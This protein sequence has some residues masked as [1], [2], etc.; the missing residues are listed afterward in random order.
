MLQNLV[1]SGSSAPPLSADFNDTKKLEQALR[2]A[3]EGE[4]RFD[5]GSRALYATDASNYRQMPIGVVIPRTID[6]AIQAMRICYQHGAPVLSRGGGTS[7]CGQCCNVAVVLDF[8]KYL[9]QIIDID[10]AGKYAWVQPGTV[11]DDLRHAAEQHGLTFA[12][13]PSTHTHNTLGGMIGNNSCGAHSVMGGET[14]DNVIELDVLTYEGVRMTLTGD[15]DQPIRAAD[16]KDQPRC[17]QIVQQLRDLGERYADQIRERFPEIPRR[18]SGF[19]LPALLPERGFNLARALVGS[20]GTCV[21]VLQAKVRLMDNPAARSLLV[22]G[23]K[24]VYEA[25]DHVPEVMQ[26]KPIALEGIDDRLISD[27][28]AIGLHPDKVQLLP[29]G[30]GWLLVEF[31]GQNKDDADAQAHKL[32]DALK[33]A[34]NAP[35]MK[36]FD[37][38]KVE[39]QIWKIRESGLGATAH[40]P[41]KKITWEGWEDSSVP[42]ENLGKYLRK[43]REL[44]D[45]Y[46]YACD[47]YGHFG[48]GCVHTRIDFDLETAEGIR[49]FRAFLHDAAHLVVSLG[50]SISGEHGDGQSKGEL[51]PIMFGDDLIQAFREFKG[52]WDPHWRMNPGKVVDPYRADQNLRLGT[53]YDPPEVKVHF[54]YPNDK[55]NFS[56]AML[57][58]VGVGECRKKS[59][60]MC[61]SYMA[62]REEMHSTR[63]RARLLFEMLNGGV[64]ADGWKNEAVFEA[65]DMCLSCK[66]CTGECPVKVDMPIYKAEFMAHYYEGRRRPLFAYGFGLIDRWARLASHMPGLANFFTQTQPFAGLAKKIGNI[67]PERRITPFARE[68]FVA[69]FKRRPPAPTNRPQVILWPDTFNN[70]FHPE[71][72]QAAVEV[73]EAAGYAVTLPKDHVCCGRP[74]Y[75]F[76]MLDRARSYL[77]SVME[78]LDADLRAGTPIIGLEPACVSVFREELPNLFSY[79]EQAMRLQ[80][81]VFLLSEFLDK[82]VE[83]YR[84]PKLARAAVVQGHCHHQ[85]VLK[86]DSE[87]AI[88]EKLGLEVNMLEAGCCGMAGSF[89]FEKDKYEVSMACGERG[90]LPAA[91]EAARDTL[92]I[93]NGFSCRE[94]I[95]QSTGRDVLHLAQ[96]LQMALHSGQPSSPPSQSR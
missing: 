86:M 14:V 43:L 46:G 21:M 55:G 51:L 49:I 59:G 85:S 20:E 83:N 22:L 92:I 65:L 6:D 27:M 80:K 28:K 94:Q 79:S 88:L 29:D 24:D 78:T 45:K 47:L 1:A 16:P 19:N 56:K 95:V 44:F 53:D 58:C 32:M 76:G 25:G 39:A 13:D 36:L 18:V 38:P 77:E 67:A 41:D 89:G 68:S 62:T 52:T 66:G 63:G 8:S 57:R 74:L 54:H 82:K 72:A 11:L 61:P 42:P 90:V 48:Q 60:T 73:L 9:N 40:V 93:A 35:S 15:A 69:W 84:I 17:D 71:V 33:D 5:D 75:E 96:V 30:K 4:V 81:Q 23:Y 2:V 34:D 50:G 10:V 70:F 91:R 7:L 12:P 31:G 64:L 37:D 3:L 87:Q 26:H